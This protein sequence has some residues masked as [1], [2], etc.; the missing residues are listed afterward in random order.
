MYQLNCLP[1][2][3]IG[4]RPTYEV[5]LL[6]HDS[7]EDLYWTNGR[8]L[9][10]FPLTIGKCLTGFRF[11][12]RSAGGTKVLSIHISTQ[13]THNHPSHPSTQNSNPFQ[14]NTSGGSRNKKSPAI[15]EDFY[16]YILLFIFQ[17]TQEF[18]HIFKHNN[19]YY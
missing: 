1:T 13:P 7:A 6:A 19:L 15:A 12:K 8:S 9:F 3:S 10:L 18:P 11:P 17:L 14:N 2:D 4:I 5:G 16:Y